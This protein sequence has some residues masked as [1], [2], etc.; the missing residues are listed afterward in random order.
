MLGSGRS[1]VSMGIM[2]SVIARSTC[3][4]AIQSCARG[5]AGLLRR[6]APRND[7]CASLRQRDEF[8]LARHVS[9]A[10]GLPVLL[11]LLDPL[12]G[13]GHEIP[14]D[15]ARAFQR[16]AAEQHHPG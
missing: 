9:K 14:P 3:D 10:P 4:E 16:V 2:K 11:G 5:G 6:F 7:G 1:L 15:M 12:F 13:R 8:V